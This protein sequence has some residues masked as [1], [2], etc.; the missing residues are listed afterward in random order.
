MIK[1]A[2]ERGWI[3]GDAVAL[4]HLTAIKRAGADII[5]TYLARELAEGCLSRA[6]GDADDAP[7]NAE[8]FDRACR[9]IPG[10]VNSP[11]RAFRSV[12][13][14]P[15]FVARAEG[16]HVWDV[17]GR[18][19][20][21][22]V[23]S[24]GAVDPGPRPPGG[25]R[26]HRAPRP[27]AAPPTARPPSGEVLLAE[28]AG[29]AGRRRRPGAPGLLRHRGHDVR[30]PPGPGRHR[31]GQ[32]RQV[33]RLLPRPL[34]RAAGRPAARAWPT[35]A[36]S[37]SAGVPAGGGGRHRRGALQR[38][39]RRSTTT[40]AV[41]IVEPVAANMGLVPPERRVPRRP[42]G[43]VRP[44]RRPADLRRGHHRLPAVPRW[45][46]RSGSASRPDLWCFGK[47]IGGG[48]PVGA[49]GGS[50]RRHGGPRPAR[51]RVPGGHAVGEPAGHRRRPRRAWPSSTRPPTNGSTD[52]RPASPTGWQ[53]AIADA[54]VAVQVPRVGPLVGPLLRRPAGAGLRRRPRTRRRTAATPRSSTPCCARASRW[55]PAPTRRSSPPSPTPRTTSSA[56]SRRRPSPPPRWRPVVSAL[57]WRPVG[58]GADGR[59]TTGGRL[60]GLAC[61]ARSV[62]PRTLEGPMKAAVLTQIPGELEIEDVGVDSA[63][64]QRGP[65][66]GRRLGPLPLRPALHGGAVADR[67]C[68]P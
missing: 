33:R 67:A 60:A 25:D 6:D 50:R 13:G 44:G 64:R 54:G 66:A 46:R 9:V 21:D 39:A 58:T 34:R 24:Y 56:R 17:E 37:G 30:H 16:A 22:Y 31:P 52:A 10:G 55:R 48:L 27:A 63:G 1:A 26:G 28:A 45:R 23:Q 38:G 53:E 49:F 19:Y 40:V 4:E 36:C 2:A 35:R 65:R 51:P 18:R 47:V 7:T 57:R 59:P 5:L 61:R 29:G 68:P 42:A 62:A 32:D 14:T 20:I 15:Y 8:L 3:D 12:G 43:R 11:V 41:V